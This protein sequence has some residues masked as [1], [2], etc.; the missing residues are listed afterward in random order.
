MANHN[1][2]IYGD[3]VPFRYYDNEVD[4]ATVRNSLNSFD[5]NEGDRIIIDIHSQ[6][7]DTTTAFG[8]LNMLQRFK[9]DHKVTLVTRVD[10]WCASSG[11][12]LLLA[13]DIRI[14]N[15]F[16]EPFV[17][18]A[19]SYVSGGQNKEDLKKVY[20]SLELTD[21]MIATLYAQKTSISKEEAAQ[22]MSEDRFLSAEESLNYGFFTELENA[23]VPDLQSSPFGGYIQNNI[24]KRGVT[25]EDIKPEIKISNNNIDMKDKSKLKA[26]FNSLSTLV[27]EF[28]GEGKKNLV[29]F[30]ADNKEV[31]FAELDENDTAGIGAQATIDG[32]AVGDIEGYDAAKGIV[33]QNGE[34]FKFEGD[35]LTEIVPVENNAE[36]MQRQIDTLTSQ[37]ATANNKLTETTNKLTAATKIVN[38]F[39][40]LKADFEEEDI[41][42][43]DVID[44][45]PK[46]D[47]K[48]KTNSISSI[49]SIRGDIK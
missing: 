32:I 7:G 14:G 13:G 19:W 20:E 6:G 27:S 43:D 30:T 41:N 9:N 38:Q 29:L 18:N 28:L 16:A 48:Q 12:I 8:I 44:D 1:L 47:P 45:E 42:E 15:S 31:S 3:I 49:A 23:I 2:T 46:R 34:V 11:V 40:K 39:N 17:H 35:K 5:V 26:A 25:K 33:M 24:S 10:G 37:L 4:L 36:V 21:N 22:L